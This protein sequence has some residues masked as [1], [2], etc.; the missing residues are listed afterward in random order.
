MKLWRWG[1]YWPSCPLCKLFNYHAGVLQEVV[2]DTPLRITNVDHL[3]KCG[4][5]RQTWSTWPIGGPP[6]TNEITHMTLPRW[7]SPTHIL[8]YLDTPL[9][10]PRNEALSL[11]HPQMPDAHANLVSTIVDIAATV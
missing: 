9:P 4:S 2:N 11:P 6:R 8:R 3:V 7:C 1:L 5:S 10:G